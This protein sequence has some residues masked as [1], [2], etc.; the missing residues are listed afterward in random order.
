MAKTPT[1]SSDGASKGK[2][3]E[4]T[5][6]DTDAGSPS[7]H[8]AVSESISGLTSD[9]AYHY[10]VVMSNP[11]GNS[12][13][14]DVECASANAVSSLT[15]E[16]VSDLTSSTVTL[17]GSWDGNGEDTHYFYEWGFATGSGF[18]HSTPAPAGD[19]GSS[20]GHQVHSLTLT[21]LAS[22]ATY[23]FRIIASDSK[24]T[25]TG[26]TLTF[27][28]FKFPSVQYLQPTKYE[29]TSIQLNTL[30]NPNGGGATTFHY[31]YGTTSA[32][33]SSTPESASIGS[34][35][36]FHEASQVI[37][38]LS[39]GTTYHYRIV[40]TGPGGPFEN[41]EDQTFTT[42]PVPPDDRRQHGHRTVT[43]RGQDQCRRE[44]R[45]RSHRRLLRIRPDAGLRELD[46][47]WAPALAADNES[48]PVSAELSGLSPDT[49][50]HYKVVAINFNGSATSSDL[51]FTTGGAPRVSGES[52]SNVTETSA[53]VSALVN[54]NLSGATYHVEYG[55]T[56]AYGSS[57]GESGA[58]GADEAAH[59]VTQDLAGLSPGTT[60]HYRVVATNAVGSTAGGDATF[61]TPMART[62]APPPPP[63]VQCKKGFVKR[64]GK[65]VKRK[66][67]KK[68][69][70]GRRS[71]SR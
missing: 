57:S 69:R 67:P 22:D 51:T 13:G 48:H 6:P 2:P 20:A 30:V 25:S 23:R 71:G 61:T 36:T 62:E 28:T 21:G 43:D 35:S 4:H 39:P 58:V 37:S 38:G 53:R 68:N 12:P 1:T 19:G 15:T 59:S 47:P 54:P 45:L 60:Y 32:Y 65:C 29:T 27:K 50:Y 49:T 52:S 10:R 46:D 18:E 11:K 33:G 7:V 26:G 9:T 66:K 56:G 31:D 55:P 70:H 42:L 64:H 40:A 41:E 8:T 63:A 17:N 44:A 34:D 5:T 24:G 3:Y 16:P 14:N